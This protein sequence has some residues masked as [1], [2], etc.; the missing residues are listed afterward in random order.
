MFPPWGPYKSRHVGVLARPLRDTLGVGSWLIGQVCGSGVGRLREEVFQRDY[1]SFRP[2]QLA[3]YPRHHSLPVALLI[4]HSGGFLIMGP[5]SMSLTTGEAGL[6]PH[7]LVIWIL[8]FPK[9]HESS[10]YF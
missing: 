10:V 4:S 8:S 5:M 1:S 7:L 3:P 6:F 2:H 9:C